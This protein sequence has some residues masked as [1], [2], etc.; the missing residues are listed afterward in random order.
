MGGMVQCGPQVC[1]AR[2]IWIGDGEW[3]FVGTQ[4]SFGA[5][6][7]TFELCK[8]VGASPLRDYLYRSMYE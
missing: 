4:L 5:K 2:V 3:M 6:F 8:V 7:H 1:A